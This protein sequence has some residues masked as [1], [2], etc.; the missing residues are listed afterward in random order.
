[1]QTELIQHVLRISASPQV[2]KTLLQNNHAG[3]NLLH[4]RWRRA[5]QHGAAITAE[6]TSENGELPLLLLKHSVLQKCDFDLRTLASIRSAC[7]ESC[8]NDAWRSIPS[9]CSI[10]SRQNIQSAFVS[11]VRMKCECIRCEMPLF[12][13][14]S[15]KTTEL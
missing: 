15:R 6:H 13:C 7:R 5:T 8:W 1:M 11:N 10:A 2:S 3:E 9:G 14:L 4:L 12:G